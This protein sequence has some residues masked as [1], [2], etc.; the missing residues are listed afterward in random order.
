MGEVSTSLNLIQLITGL[1]RS[2]LLTR[3]DIPLRTETDILN[4]NYFKSRLNDGMI[5]EAKAIDTITDNFLRG[6]T[7][8]RDIRHGVLF[9]PAND[10]IRKQAA[11]QILNDIKT[12]AIR[13][14]TG[15]E[16]YDEQ[17]FCTIMS[18]VLVLEPDR[19][20]DYHNVQVYEKVRGIFNEL[21]RN[22][23]PEDNKIQKVHW[24]TLL[25]KC[26]SAFPP[27]FAN[28]ESY[29]EFVIPISGSSGTSGG[30]G[31]GDGG[32]QDDDDEDSIDDLKDKVDK[33]TR[34]FDDLTVRETAWQN[35]S[36]NFARSK[37][38]ADERSNKLDSQLKAANEQIE[39]LTGFIKSKTQWQ[40]YIIWLSKKPR[41]PASFQLEKFASIML[42]S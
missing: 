10:D 38:L 21:I 29:T 20:I 35:S 4:S 36:A 16:L 6:I 5:D 11:K 22:L 32:S 42:P 15:N 24:N 7:L 25:R 39:Y 14:F 37:Q 28:R 13:I 17:I 41:I 26:V 31:T 30:G 34:D 23:S 9:E 1:N 3:D 12:H 40:E 2:D 19:S 18:F 8:N 33:L 27:N